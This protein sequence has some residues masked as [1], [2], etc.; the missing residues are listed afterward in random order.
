MPA[1]ST[2]G[3]APRTGS[4]AVRGGRALSE[5][6]SSRCCR[7][8]CGPGL[9]V[10]IPFGFL[11]PLCALRCPH[12]S[13]QWQATKLS[14]VGEAFKVGLSGCSASDPEAHTHHPCT[15][16]SIW[17]GQEWGSWVHELC[18]PE[19]WRVWLLAW[20]VSAGWFLLQASKTVRRPRGV[21]WLACGPGQAAHCW[22]GGVDD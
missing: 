1:V 11:W 7:S 4:Y 13:V 16:A 21:G 19:E 14:L 18:V 10:F 9:S 8:S 22:L 2:A 3:P 5:A 17:Q 20:Q 15:V 12:V 6:S